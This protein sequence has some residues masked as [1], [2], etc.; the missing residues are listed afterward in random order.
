MSNQIQGTVKA[1]LD[2]I[3]RGNTTIQTV[4]IELPTQSQYPEIAVV[5]FV[6]KRYEKLRD[7]L[8]RLQVG[9]QIEVGFN[10]N[11]REYQ[12]KWYMSL[13]GWKIFVQDGYSTPQYE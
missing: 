13:S 6:G 5:E 4:A 7:K 8:D 2:P 10:Y 12:G 3:Q 11:G 1:I 9:Q